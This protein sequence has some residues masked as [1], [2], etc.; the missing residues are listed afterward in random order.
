MQVKSISVADTD[1]AVATRMERQHVLYDSSKSIDLLMLESAL[2]HPQVTGDELIAQI[3]RIRALAGTVH[4]GVIP[5]SAELC[6]L[7]LHGVWIYDDL[8]EI[9]LVH[10]TITTTDANDLKLYNDW[11]DQLWKSA[12][13]GANLRR[14][15]D[16]ITGA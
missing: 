10:T 4:I 1:A 16:S 12:V 13:T 6:I 3:D 2:R 8:V 11:L 9:E 7:P 15:L 5:Q 14:L